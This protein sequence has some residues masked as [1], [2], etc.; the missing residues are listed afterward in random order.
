MGA[1]AL[2][3]ALIPAC[4]RS[5]GEPGKGAEAA[6]EAKAGTPEG[7]APS[8][9]GLVT[10]AEDARRTL[11]VA[12]LEQVEGQLEAAG[13]TR[14]AQRERLATLATLAVE[15][16]VRSAALGDDQ[17]AAQAARLASEGQAL[18]DAI[19][20]QLDPGELAAAKARLSLARDED[21]AAE[22]PSV[23]LPTFR[24]RELQS[25]VLARPVW[26]GDDDALV[27]QER[28][29]LVTVLQDL[30]EPTGLER[31]LLAVTLHAAGESERA[32]AVARDALGAAPGQPLAQGLLDRIRDDGRV[33]VADPSTPVG[34]PTTPE[35]PQPEPVAEPEPEP[36]AE[37]EPEPTTPDAGDPKPKAKPKAPPKPKMTP[38]EL[39]TEGCKQVRSGD[40]QK[41]FAMLQKAFDLDPRDTKVI[42]CMA[43]GHMKLGRLPSARAMAERVLRSSPKNKKALLLGAKIEDRMGN[44]RAAVDYYRKVLEQEPDN[45]TAKDYVD[46]NG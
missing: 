20:A 18:A 12:K 22:H 11:D 39:T 40:A 30:S 27:D 6:P 16:R 33:A 24:D 2:A 37:P 43:E 8:V 35:P 26:H 23:L 41:G 44:K 5:S 7:G 31:M 4:D 14:D 10:E 21:V 34:T 25:A 45:S 9:T 46:K 29:D 19:G 42:L 32:A 36:I 3:L 13:A 15:A 38:D 1:L 17:A 28:A